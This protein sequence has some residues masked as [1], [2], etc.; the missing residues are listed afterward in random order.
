MN[1]E[2]LLMNNTD[3]T[4]FSTGTSRVVDRCQICDATD[5]IPIIFLGYLPPVNQMYDIG[6]KP[7][8]QPS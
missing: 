1:V 2:K 7:H 8:E 5:L 4:I 3:Q 6:Q